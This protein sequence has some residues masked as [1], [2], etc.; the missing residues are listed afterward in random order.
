MAINRSNG[1]P[2]WVRDIASAQGLTTDESIVYVSDKDDHVWALDRNTG[3]TIWVQNQ[4]EYRQLS[5]PMLL[6]DYIL[7]GDFDGYVHVLSKQD[8]SIVG[9]K[10]IAS[11]RL[12]AAGTSTALQTHIVQRNGRLSA[13]SIQ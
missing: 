5:A 3:G 9:R 13:I 10:E 7:V 12:F 2:I 1:Q 4:L 11:Q 6:A 8:G